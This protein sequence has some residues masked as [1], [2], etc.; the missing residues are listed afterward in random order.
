MILPLLSF[1]PII[2]FLAGIASMVLMYAAYYYIYKE[3]R[4]EKA[5]LR[6]VLSIIFPFLVPFFIYGIGKDKVIPKQESESIQH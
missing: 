4:G 5:T 3:Y 6:I 2:G 1:V